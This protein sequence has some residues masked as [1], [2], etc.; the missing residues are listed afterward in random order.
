MGM[1]QQMKLSSSS[2][3]NIAKNNSSHA[4]IDV[5]FL[6][7]HLS[8]NNKTY[9]TKPLK[10]QPSSRS[11]NKVNDVLTSVTAPSFR[12][13]TAM[14]ANGSSSRISN[15]PNGSS[16]TFNPTSSDS[17]IP[18]TDD[19]ATAN[20]NALPANGEIDLLEGFFTPIPTP[21]KSE[22]SLSPNTESVKAYSTRVPIK[23][24]STV[25]RGS[26][27]ERI[28]EKKDDALA[29]LVDMG[30]GIDQA[31][32]A[33]NQTNSGYDVESA[34]NMLTLED[35]SDG[36]EFQQT[37]IPNHFATSNSDSLGD[38]VNDISNEIFT[39]AS[40]L[41][42]T[43]RDKLQQGIETY[44]QQQNERRGNEPAWMKNR[45][46]YKK[47]SIGLMDEAEELTKDDI[48][49]LTADQRAKDRRF[50]LNKIPLSSTES[51]DIQHEY[52]PSGSE[53]S[54]L[55]L[56]HPVESISR[57][58]DRD[59]SEQSFIHPPYDVRHN[60][61]RQQTIHQN[62][63]NSKNF[64]SKSPDEALVDIMGTPAPNSSGNAPSSNTASDIGKMI[65]YDRPSMPFGIAREEGGNA[66][67]SGDFPKALECYQEALQFLGGDHPLRIL[68]YSNLAIVFEKLGSS[69]DE[70]NACTNGLEMISKVSKDD[71]S[72]LDELMLEP[73]KSLKKFWVKL[74]LKRA[75]ALEHLEKFEDAFKA[76]DEL[77][78]NG[79]SSKAVLESRRRCLSVIQPKPKP[80]AR[81]NRIVNHRAPKPSRSSTPARESETLRRVRKQEKDEEKEQEETF[82]LHD[83]VESIL[84]RW[85]NGKKDNI[86]ALLSSLH[87]V[88]WPD[89]HWKPVSMTDLVLD[90][91]VK[92]T[93]LKA[94]SK[95]HPDKL[96]NR[97]TTEQKMI[98]NG[99]FITVNEA[100]E[101]YKQ[102][103]NIK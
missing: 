75:E 52:E 88:L 67:K 61:V 55:S 99:V 17:S 46:T 70:L 39:K 44:K 86:R 9:S 89:L 54:D 41:F 23:D 56:S 13:Q 78:K 63:D 25:Q 28:E 1:A 76:Y 24:D 27:K 65:S 33:L 80:S 74:N 2:L 66:F 102:T 97:V 96:G 45:E 92:I 64:K 32:R 83:K 36:Q 68:M 8:G 82:R 14:L 7:N 69:R 21:D 91:K 51:R 98:A 18:M 84:Q 48:R 5:D 59:T 93:Y 49:R 11:K 85:S 62:M 94:V 19:I 87:E 60:T 30:F 90:K 42:K 73:N 34:V 72:R 37:Y 15:G 103:N 6:E 20:N 101:T 12:S 26:H 81:K 29:T 50:H 40:R 3:S 95:V 38:V 71:V 10:V 43:G 31:A 47:Q 16:Q 57:N 22:T 35:S 58:Y 4:S 79:F 77:L 100:W 53:S